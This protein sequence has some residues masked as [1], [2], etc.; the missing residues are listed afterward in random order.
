MTEQTK[1]QPT[2]KPIKLDFIVWQE[3]DKL[4][5]ELGEERGYPKELLKNVVAEAVKFYRDNRKGLKNG[6]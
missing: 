4:A 3:I 2:Q 5:V 1:T 6:K